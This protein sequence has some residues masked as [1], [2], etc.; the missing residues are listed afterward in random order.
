MAMHVIGLWSMISSKL[1]ISTQARLEQA[2]KR[3]DKARSNDEGIWERAVNGRRMQDARV[4][5]G[6]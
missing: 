4:T 3:A 2:F 5:S 1:I 6:S